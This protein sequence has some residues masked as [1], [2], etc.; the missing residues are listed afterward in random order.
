[1]NTVLRLTD[2]GVRG[3]FKGCFLGLLTA[4]LPALAHAQAPAA[5]PA[6]TPAQA[7]SPV[8]ADPNRTPAQAA[9][10]TPATP[11]PNPNLPAPPAGAPSPAATGTPAPKPKAS[12]SPTPATP[13][14]QPS[15]QALVD[16]LSG[17]DIRQALDLIRAH[18]VNAAAL[19]ED[20]LNRATLQGLLERLA[21]G[22]LIESPDAAPPPDEP[23]RAEILDDRV[24]YIRLGS[25]SADR[26]AEFEATLASFTEKKIRAMVLDLRSTPPSTDFD[27]AADFAKRLT[28]KGKMLFAVRR[29]SEKQ[30]Q[31]FTSSQDPVFDGVIVSIVN[32]NT[33]GAGE[34]IAAILRSLHHGLV[35]GETTAGEAAE[36]SVQPLRGGKRLRVAVA[37]VKLPGEVSI[38]PEGLKPDVQVVVP[39]KQEVEALAVGRERGV[40]GLVF[41][42]ERA[43]I[44]E[45]A[46]VAGTNPELDA[47]E[48][49]Q[50]LGGN[51]RKPRLTDPA[52]Q[53]AVDL[54]TAIVIFNQE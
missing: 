54:V 22:V 6:A 24:G 47:A 41:E 42:T 4:L 27:L 48:E 35:V 32:R 39:P 14:P 50:R 5:P 20:A 8:V 30:E 7:A 9:P 10:A 29:P 51:A 31:M 16:G 37:E 15:P 21:P 1:M 45:A 12:P 28:P 18:Y 38:F 17:S 33:A 25:L 13:T 52:L 19:S 2:R 43:R 44:N 53:R 49:A 40:S 46:L 11:A 3:V 23:L 34:V 36:F 26:L